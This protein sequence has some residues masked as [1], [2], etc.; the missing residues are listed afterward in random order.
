MN[1]NRAKKNWFVL[2]ILSIIL[3]GGIIVV[4]QSMS[5]YDIHNFDLSNLTEIRISDRG[6]L[7]NTKKVIEDH[8]TVE[9]FVHLLKSSIKVD[10]S[11]A[12]LKLNQGL[13]DV[14]LVYKNNS[15]KAVSIVK[16]LQGGIIT[17]GQHC[18]RSDSIL[19]MIIRTLKE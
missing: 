13:C 12:N 14:E 17:S 8:E 15:I 10:Q 4:F 16:T 7:G 9:S 19:S 18:Y 11:E 3:F 2:V 1:I 6:L 5:N